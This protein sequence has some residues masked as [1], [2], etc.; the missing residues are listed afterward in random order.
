MERN[1]RVFEG[2][3]EPTSSVFLKA[4][5]LACLWGLKSHHLGDYSITSTKQGWVSFF[6]DH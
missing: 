3:C 5:D 2:H 4:K 6:V 1:H